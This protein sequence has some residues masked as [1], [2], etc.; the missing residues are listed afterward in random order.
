MLRP[1]KRAK[2]TEDST[3]LVQEAADEEA[4]S[5][6]YELEEVEL[7]LVHV[8]KS[9]GVAEICKTIKAEIDTS[10]A[11]QTAFKTLASVGHFYFSCGDQV[12]AVSPA[13][14]FYDS[15]GL[16]LALFALKKFPH[17]RDVLFPVLDTI[18][19]YAK[20]DVERALTFCAVDDAIDIL[21]NCVRNHYDKPEIICITQEAF[22]SLVLNDDI[23]LHIA[24][25]ALIKEL[26]ELLRRFKSHIEV[27]R[28]LL[29]PLSHLVVLKNMASEFVQLN[30][31]PDTLSILKSYK[32]DQQV[33][34]YAL[35]LLNALTTDVYHTTIIAS[36]S[37]QRSVHTIAR[38]I[39]KHVD[40]EEITL[41]G[42]QLLE[43]IASLPDF[44]QVINQNTILE[45]AYHALSLYKGAQYTHTRLE[46]KKRALTFQTC[47]IQD[48]RA[49]ALQERRTK[50]DC[51]LYTCFLLLTAIAA[52]L[53]PYNQHTS[54]ET[55]TL[56]HALH[57]PKTFR[58]TGAVWS[59]LN[60]PFSHAVFPTVPTGSMATPNMLGG[61]NILLGSVQLVQTRL[62]PS[63][64][65]AEQAAFGPWDSAERG[66]VT[67]L[68]NSTLA[69]ACSS[70]VS[71]ALL[72]LQSAGWLDNLTNSVKVQWNV[73]NAA[74]D[75]HVA[76]EMRLNFPVGGFIQAA[77]DATPAYF[78][79]YQ[80]LF[81]ISLLFYVDVAMLC[82]TI[83]SVWLA[84]G[85]LQ[86][87]RQYY[88][89]IAAHLV[90]FSMVVLW[91]SVW[92][93]RVQFLVT[94][95][96]SLITQLAGPSYVSLRDV[97]LL[98]QQ[99]RVLFAFVSLIMW[100]N[101]P[102]YL[103]LH[104]LRYLLCVLEATNGYI[105]A[106]IALVL[107]VLVGVAHCLTLA[108]SESPSS[109]IDWVVYGLNAMCRGTLL[110]S[111]TYFFFVFN[112][113]LSLVVVYLLVPLLRMGFAL[114]PREPPRRMLKPVSSPRKGHRRANM[115]A[116]FR[117]AKTVLKR[118][119]EE[120]Q[121]TVR[122]V[123][124]SPWEMSEANDA[125]IT[126]VDRGIPSMLQELHRGIARLA[127]L[128]HDLDD[129][130]SN[131]LKRLQQLHLLLRGNFSRSIKTPPTLGSTKAE[132]NT[133]YAQRR[134]YS[135]TASDDN[136]TDL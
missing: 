123:S 97:T 51:V 117:T 59:Y 17:H 53:S 43:S 106:Y 9:N 37:E 12:L 107:V 99:E 64:I 32:D 20:L 16:L 95:S 14:G 120:R 23:R 100:F 45:L 124:F 118:M 92:C 49:Y 74:L 15:D 94:A 130:T 112:L 4:S 70:N 47:A 82:F 78:N 111:S 98:A 101:W 86:R 24:S 40:I 96:F 126:A 61:S 1:N 67:L 56:I 55:K 48:G 65:A 46:I 129:V 21:M 63:G 29:Y 114:C 58:D 90:D 121:Q 109:W 77:V 88:F 36:L 83:Y 6:H 131:L 33:A 66:Y 119:L 8:L 41:E 3:P 62:N 30:G 80:G 25:S 54:N 13:D 76:M 71:C 50:G 69:P 89:H 11:V 19:I 31:I 57:L 104:N 7:Q 27:S 115:K 60:G 91:L 110:S 87:Y 127:M 132:F 2:A 72:N 68:P 79:I 44:F 35:A 128:D 73:Y 5:S 116:A 18:S 113:A 125:A 81:L 134:I 133:S 39:A 135:T 103:S 84:V 38:A 93:T 28:A 108:V 136:T 22:G 122:K 105:V 10:W 85:K 34:W 75:V 52:A 102:R 42:F 26:T